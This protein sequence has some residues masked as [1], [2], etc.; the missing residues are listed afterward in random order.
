[1][2]KIISAKAYAN[3]EIALVAWKLD[4][5]IPGCLGFEVTRI[6]VDDGSEVVLAA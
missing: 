2:P 1:M 3:N 4:T 5:P 6:Y